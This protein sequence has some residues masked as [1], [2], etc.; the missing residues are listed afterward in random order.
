[1]SNEKERV[2]EGLKQ[3]MQA[4]VDGHNF[5]KMASNN[6]KDEDGKKVFQMLAKDEIDHFSFLK[7]QYESIRAKG[8][9]NP[10]VKLG[11]PSETEETPIFSDDFKNRLKE[12]HI[13]MSA[14]SVGA[15]LELASIKF[16]KAES[17]KAQDPD[18]KKF[19]LEL[20]DWETTHHRRLVR[21]QEELQEDYFH[22]N[23]FYPF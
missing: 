10:D 22:D 15:Q 13:E 3:A 2:L 11:K 6:M 14:L 19:Y 5:Y 16:Y 17:D 7:A 18:V 1:M 23:R 12:A 9:V 4:E 20:A 21:Q 8:K